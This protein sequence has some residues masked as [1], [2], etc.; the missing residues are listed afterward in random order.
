MIT[1]QRDQ[2]SRATAI[3][4][5]DQIHPFQVTRHDTGELIWLVQSRRDPTRY[6]LITVSG[7]NVHCGCPQA[8]YHG[9]CAHGAA[10]RL[11]LQA[12]QQMH[13]CPPF[14][15]H[16]QPAPPKYARPQLRSEPQM[17]QERRQREDAE[18][19]ERSLP[20]TDDK[21]FSMWKS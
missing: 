20:W 18:R 10:V 19:R 12:Q 17:E 1:P 15:E 7:D 3:A 5:R 4:H 8:Q 6:Y 11:A 2:F 21:P 9:I 16:A 13:I 14:H